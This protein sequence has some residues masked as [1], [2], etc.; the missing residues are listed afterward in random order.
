M[1]ISCKS[2]GSQGFEPRTN[3]QCSFCDGTE[4]GQVFGRLVP[5]SNEPE[6]LVPLSNET[7]VD[8]VAINHLFHKLWTAAVNSPDYIKKDWKQFQKILNAILPQ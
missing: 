8:P 7:M 5:L 3:G 2:C 6:R 1:L 4:G